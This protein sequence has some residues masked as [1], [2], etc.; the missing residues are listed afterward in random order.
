MLGFIMKVHQS[1][2]IHPV[3]KEHSGIIQHRTSFSIDHEVRDLISAL[4]PLLKGSSL[5]I[6]SGFHETNRARPDTRGVPL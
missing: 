6:P 5:I 2:E 1:A 3:L 4:T